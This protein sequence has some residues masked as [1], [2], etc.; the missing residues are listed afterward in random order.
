MS[1]WYDVIVVGAGPA[2]ARLAWLLSENGLKVLIL[3]KKELPRYKA[4]GGGLTR[5]AL[6]HL[7]LDLGEV[8]EDRA[9]R[10]RLAYQKKTVLEK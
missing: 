5:R 9:G 1:S 4:C 7:P 10:V 3:E 2:G 8:I 6:E